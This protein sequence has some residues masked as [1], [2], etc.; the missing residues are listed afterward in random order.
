[1]RAAVVE[2]DGVCAGV[3][4]AFYGVG[5]TFGSDSNIA[6]TMTARS[7]QSFLTSAISRRFTSKGRSEISS[8]LLIAASLL[9]LYSQPP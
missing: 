6:E 1:M 9:P 8:M 5:P 3:F 2:F 7:G 4:D